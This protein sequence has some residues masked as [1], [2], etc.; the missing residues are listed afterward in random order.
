MERRVAERVRGA[1]GPLGF[2]AHAFKVRAARGLAVASPAGAS[3]RAASP[4]PGCGAVRFP[5]PGGDSCRRCGERRRA[6]A[7]GPPGGSAT[8][9]PGEARPFAPPVSPRLPSRLQLCPGRLRRQDEP[10]CERAAAGG[11]RCVPA[12]QAPLG[13]QRGPARSCPEDLGE[14]GK[15]ALPSAGCGWKCSSGACCAAASRGERASVRSAQSARYG[16]SRL[17]LRPGTAR[18]PAELQVCSGP[19]RWSWSVK[20]RRVK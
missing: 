6:Q 18:A 20:V 2:E 8:T 15:S 7:P 14:R 19:L 11:R 16:R 4:A 5:Q 9:V 13:V 17:L 12:P 1:L 10:R 3:V